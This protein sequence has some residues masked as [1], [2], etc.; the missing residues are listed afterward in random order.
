MEQTRKETN[1]VQ[2]VP[3]PVWEVGVGNIRRSSARGYLT[4][5]CHR[6]LVCVW[7]YPLQDGERLS[8]SVEG[9]G[10]RGG[11][12]RQEAAGSWEF[13]CL[14]PGL[15]GPSRGNRREWSPDPLHS[16]HPDYIRVPVNLTYLFC[17]RAGSAG[18]LTLKDGSADAIRR[19]AW[20]EPAAAWPTSGSG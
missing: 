16:G 14:F 11:S 17:M 13:I 15:L 9:G 18:A 12:W 7:R 3:F 8:R 10:M 6:A 1:K 4:S 2:S 5:V 20:E 19:C